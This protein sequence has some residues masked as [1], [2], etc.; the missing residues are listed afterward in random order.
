MLQHQEQ[1]VKS[2]HGGTNRSLDSSVGNHKRVKDGNYNFVSSKEDEVLTGSGV[3]DENRNQ[4]RPRSLGPLGRDPPNFSPSSHHNS[5]ILSP[6]SRRP[7]WNLLEPL[8]EIE[9]GDDGYGRV[10]PDGAE[11]RRM[12]EE[13]GIYC[14]EDEKQQ[15]KLGQ[16]RRKSSLDFTSQQEE[17][18]FAQEDKDEWGDSGSESEHSF[19]SESSRSSLNLESGGEG[20]LAGGWDRIGVGEPKLNQQEEN[21][22]SREVLARSKNFSQ[23]KS[24]TGRTLGN[25]LEEGQENENDDKSSDSDGELPDMMDAVWT[26]RDREHFKA[27]EMEKHQ[28][29][30][31]MYR[32]LALIRWVRTLQGRVQEQQNRLQSSFDVILTQRKELLRMGT[33]AA[34]TTAAAPVAAVSQS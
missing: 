29:Q 9:G 15:K 13:E 30:L 5:G 31:T 26:L 20:M 1:P 12:E 17:D 34:M 6:R 32:R 24:M 19:Q 11:E 3:G 4:V 25:V 23:F 8:H 21:R 2:R 10:P 33:A 7:C 16:L 14:Q 22:G 28:V 27:Q 18:L